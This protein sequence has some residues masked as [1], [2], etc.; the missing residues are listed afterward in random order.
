MKKKLKVLLSILAFSGL[1]GVSAACGGTS[2]SSGSESDS[3]SVETEV[4]TYTVKFV[5]E[6]GSTISETKYEE[7]ATIVEPTAPTKEADASYTY[8]FAGWDSEVAETVTG[9]V[10]YK[11]TYNKKAIEYT[12]TFKADG[13][14]VG[15]VQKYTVENKEITV[16][17]VPAKA[18]YTGAWEAY[19]LTTGNVE[20]KAV[21]T[22]VEYKIT[23]M[24]GD[25]SVG[26]VAFNAENTDKQAPA[27]PEKTGYTGAWSAYDFTKL[28]NQT[29]N[30]IYTAIEYT[31]TF[32]ADGA[33]VGE[34]QKYTVENKEITVPEVP[35]KAHYTGAWEAYELTTGNVEVKAV[36]TPVEYK[37][38]FMNG[39]TSVGEV[40]FNVEN[41]DKQAPAVPEKT[42]YTGTWSAYDFTKLENQTANV[43][44]V[45]NKYTVTC[46]LKGGSGDA[47]LVVT[48]DETYTLKKATAPKSYQEFLYYQDENGEKFEMQGT[49]TIASD[50]TL[51]AVYSEGVAF[52]TLESVPTYI[53][54][55]RI[56]TFSIVEDSTK[57]GKMLQA[58]T[59]AD[60][61]G[62]T[63][64][65]I[66]VDF[67]KEIFADSSV[68]YM[69]FDVMT[70]S[71]VSGTFVTN[72][73]NVY[74]H[75]YR[76]SSSGTWT[77]Y[78]SGNSQY[79]YV[80][81][82]AFKTYY[83][84]RAIYE[85]WV[86]N[87]LT[88]GRFIMAGGE[89]GISGGASFYIDNIRPATA[90]EY[91][92]SE[93][94]F[95]RG[96]LRTNNGNTVLFYSGNE[97]AWDLG[98]Q[99][100]EPTKTGFT[101]SNVSDGGRAWTFTRNKG[102]SAS[103]FVFNHTAD[104][105]MDLALRAAGYASF[106]LYVPEGSDATMGYTTTE[107]NNAPLKVGAWTTIYVEIPSDTSVNTFFSLTDTTGGTYVIDNFRLLTENEYMLAGLGFETNAGTI[108]LTSIGDD[109]TKSSVYY[110]TTADYDGSKKFAFA[111]EEGGENDVA[112]LSNVR[113]ESEIVH[114]G[115]YSFAFDKKSGYMYMTM[116]TDSPSYELLKNGFTFWIYSTTAINGVDTNNFVNGVNG[117][118]NGGAGLTINANEWTKI[119]VTAD[120]INSGGRFL[121][122][123][124]SV[125]G[126]I[127][128]DDICPLS[129]E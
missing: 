34:V 65:Y 105:K 70:D 79:N 126:T 24:N 73:F 82:D 21:Y 96:N 53:S 109:T 12:V 104:S 44:Y 19:E 56:Q 116:R 36:Y 125:T 23:F 9:D 13:A 4:G 85:S 84:P 95:E 28:E 40:A 31:V 98:I 115:S 71:K 106:D 61:T 49:W 48:Y 29:A 110:Y 51:T 101:N 114:S 63:A 18:H 54:G 67:L 76:S 58:I 108:R 16:P 78:E 123:Q 69:A 120:D 103:A 121:I 113:Y 129:A 77:R 32:K 87:N 17:E 91:A 102:A 118:F 41:T 35:A 97:N 62:D 50:V 20:V 22:P 3:T 88:S 68:E 112:T 52:D 66:T 60:S 86:E 25:A 55:S 124:G 45:A 119:T 15:E 38:T 14:T 5:D 7:G 30:V 37:I 94:S 57:D 10:T 117:K 74:Y 107:Y 2:Q 81:T 33:T 1:I 27:I 46:E 43:N 11:A 100:V 93:Y 92:N 72:S 127:Y 89:T 42:G 90:S 99:N 122:M 26:E 59:T 75:D 128:I 47:S 8:E 83:F 111:M 39:D 80:P 6:D 64:L